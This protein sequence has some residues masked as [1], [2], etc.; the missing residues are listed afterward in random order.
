MQLFSL[1]LRQ[2]VRSLIKAPLYA[3][4]VIATLALGIGAN[5]AIFSIV[6]GV[7]LR[8]LAYPNPEQ[9]MFLTTRF[10]GLRLPW[11]LILSC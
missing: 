11:P 2:A 7:V 1:D 5:S 8:P 10:P 9:L 3:A 4:V 6:N